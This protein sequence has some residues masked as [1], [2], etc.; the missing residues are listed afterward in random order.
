MKNI[1]VLLISLFITSTALLSQNKANNYVVLLDL[2]DRIIQKHQKDYDI[3]VIKTVFKKFEQSAQQNLFVKSEDAFCVRVI[4]QDG[5]AIDA[6]D[7]GQLLSLDLGQVSP[8]NRVS[9]FRKFK[10]NFYSHLSGLYDKAKF[11]DKSSD[12]KGVDIWQY[13][14][15]SLEY[16]LD[17]YKQNTLVVLSDGYFDFESFPQGFKN[18]NKFTSTAFIKNL[19]SQNWREIDKKNDY[20]IIPIRSFDKYQINVIVAGIRPKPYVN[21]LDENNII[22]YIW[23]KW[24]NEMNISEHT[25]ISYANSP[26]VYNIIAKTIQE[27][28]EKQKNVCYG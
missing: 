9:E 21:F 22:K 13:F 6:Y 26:S 4:P 24:L 23:S 16:D 10:Q 7:Y 11:S 14:N 27:N 15:E 25:E 17:L 2:S 5:S 28:Y 19:R 18:K 3:K 8:Q 12:Y 20:G 1:T